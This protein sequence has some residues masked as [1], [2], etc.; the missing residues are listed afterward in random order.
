MNYV[1]EKGLI[2]SSTLKHPLSYFL[3]PLVEKIIPCFI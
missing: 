2:F 3:M 1:P